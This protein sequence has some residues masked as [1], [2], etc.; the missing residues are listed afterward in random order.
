[1]VKL[2]L[3]KR[4]FWILVISAVECLYFPINS[5]VKGGIAPRTQLDVFPIIPIWV[6]PY[7]LCY[8]FWIFSL[9]WVVLKMD[10]KNFKA[11]IAACLLSFS[12]GVATFILFPTYVIPPQLESK[13]VFVDLLRSVYVF[14]G[15]YNAFPSG[16]VYITT[17]MALFFSRCYPRQRWMWAA[18]V[19]IV[20]LSTLFTGQHYL[21][22]VF[23]GLFVALVGYHFGLWWAGLLPASKRLKP[24][25]S[26]PLR[27]HR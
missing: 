18:I 20:S 4:V 26:S 27:T 25:H 1:M 13:G 22:D 3:A 24:P 16:H 5:G 21:V 9:I 12:M 2:I 15:G 23:G 10:E 19:A 14:A 6:V 17:L 8:P 11:I 7:L